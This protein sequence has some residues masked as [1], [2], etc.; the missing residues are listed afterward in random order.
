MQPGTCS[1][2]CSGAAPPRCISARA[3]SAAALVSVASSYPEDVLVAIAAMRLGRPV[4]W[5]EDRR[6][7]L[8]AANHSREQRH[9]VR[10]AVDAEGRILALEDEFCLDQGAYVRTHGARVVEMTMAMLPGPYRIPA[11]RAIGYFRLTNKTPAA[12][13]RSPGRYEG[14]FVRERLV[15]AIANQLGLDPVTMRR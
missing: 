8:M 12:T 7:H 1:P 6:E 10:A 2:A 15:D 13:Y 14:T 9:H 11:Y 4:K 5:I 3:M